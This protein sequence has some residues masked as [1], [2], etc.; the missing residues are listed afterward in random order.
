MYSELL[1]FEGRH[2]EFYKKLKYSEGYE[3]ISI[4]EFVQDL[5][6][7]PDVD[8][9]FQIVDVSTLAS[10][11]DIQYI[12]ELILPKFSTG[13]IFIA[14]IKFEEILTHNLRYCFEEFN[15]IDIVEDLEKSNEEIQKELDD[16][17]IKIIDLN[18]ADLIEFYK[19]FY[20]NLYGHEKFKDEFADLIRN[21]RVFNKLGE[22]KILSL[23]LMGDS[24]VGKTEVA[25]IIHKSLGGKKRLAKINFGN[26]SSDN[27]LN[28]LIGSPRGYIG[29]EEGEIFIRVK[30]SDTGL[31]LI[32][33]FEKSNSTLF[34]YFLDVLENG[35]MVSSVAEEIDLNGYIIIFT[36]NISK[37]DFSQRI[38]PELRSRFDYKG[39]FT[40]LYP[41][42]KRKF[43]QFRVQNIVEKFNKNFSFQL[44]PE[45]HSEILERI[46]VNQYKNMRDLN[47]KIKDTFVDFVSEIMQK[48]NEE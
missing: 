32:D 43:V 10:L 42:D 26:Y 23:F 6:K 25:R 46:D 34:N 27:S 48:E 30:N 8:A 19:S 38:S 29:S 28:S 37:E 11:R 40:L 7:V 45:M 17:T 5:N 47:K 33:E 35:K 15:K 21:F 9:I 20:Q 13:T 1:F 18:H 16:R 36:S 12:A 22:H 4:T 41:E 2:F 24:G 39:Y 3:I 31:I 14:D 44:I